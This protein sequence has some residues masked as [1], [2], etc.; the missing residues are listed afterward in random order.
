MNDRART[1][2][3][4]VGIVVPARD[5]AA[6]LPRAL[7]ALASAVRA[8][9]TRAL[10]VVVAN[11]C[12]DET[13][14]LARAAGERLGLVVRV[15]ETSLPRGSGVG[16]ARHIGMQ[17]AGRTLDDEACLLTSDADCLVRRDWVRASLR[18]LARAD[19]VCGNVVPDVTEFDP[20]SSSVL[21]L[22]A[23]EQAYERLTLHYRALHEPDELN[24]WPHHGRAAG[25]SLGFRARAYREAGGFDDV[26]SDED[27]LIVERMKNRGLRVVHADDVV[28]T[29]SWRTDGRVVGGM[30]TALAER[31]ASADP[32]VARRLMPARV[33]RGWVALRARCRRAIRNPREARELL[34]ECGRLAPLD[35][36]ELSFATLWECIEPRHP[37]LRHARLRASD[38]E[39]ELTELQ[40]LVR[41]DDDVARW[42]GAGTTRPSRSEAV[43]RRP[44]APALEPTGAGE[45]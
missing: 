34:R 32:P 16:L 12:R 10:V 36:C 30:A 29:A 25:A 44:P 31:L 40:R 3:T 19:A 45:A 43:L 20:R 33:L 5:E 18:A 35:E 15:V 11:E 38:L 37:Q 8:A 21:A 4:A 41:R 7:A 13:A 2:R 39:H 22:G 28:V 26:T 23:L 6:R 17:S 24:P 9:E 42:P 14:A 1:D 27:R